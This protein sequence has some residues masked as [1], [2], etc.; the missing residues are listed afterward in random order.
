MYIHVACVVAATGFSLRLWVLFG[1]KAARAKNTVTTNESILAECGNALVVYSPQSNELCS[2][3]VRITFNY[4][5][6]PKR[7]SNQNATYCSLKQ[8]KRAASLIRVLITG[9]STNLDWDW[10]SVVANERIVV[11]IQIF[12]KQRTNQ[13]NIHEDTCDRKN[14]NG[15]WQ[16]TNSL[17][18]TRLLI[19][20]GIV[21]SKALYERVRE[22]AQTV[23]TN[24]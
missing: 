17:K 5:S 8:S 1:E 10:T 13:E 21:P 14:D 19:S 24:H 4:T 6:F 15:T 20:D 23:K 18:L 22:A 7:Q 16:L 12:C 3:I 2:Q 9:D 11:E